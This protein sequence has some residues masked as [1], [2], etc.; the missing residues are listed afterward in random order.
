LEFKYLNFKYVQPHYINGIQAD[1][2]KKAALIGSVEVAFKQDFLFRPGQRQ[3]SWKKRTVTMLAKKR[4][5]AQRTSSTI[6]MKPV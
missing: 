4:G 2:G 3:K 1:I 5:K 6:C